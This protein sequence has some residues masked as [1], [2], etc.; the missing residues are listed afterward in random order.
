[1]ARLSQE[2]LDGLF[3]KCAVRYGSAWF[4]KWDGV[5]MEVV[6]ADWAEH[7]GG[8]GIAA[9][10]HGLLNLPD[11]PPTAIDFKRVALQRPEPELPRLPAPK[12]D[13]EKVKAI[14][15]NLKIG[16]KGRTQWAYD[17]QEAEKAGRALTEAQRRAWRDAMTDAPATRCG[18]VF[19]NIDPACLPP[20][21]RA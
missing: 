16:R 10:T 3:T 11:F 18:M 9:I 8:L 15:S 14:L 1:M 21:M 6:K 13:P 4:A 20:G 17:L 12:A 19:S 5:P 2:L 7:L